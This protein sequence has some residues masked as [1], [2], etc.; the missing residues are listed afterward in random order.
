MTNR[1]L[2][3]AT[4]IASTIGLCS[5]SFTIGGNKAK[6]PP[7]AAQAVPT[8]DAG[9]LSGIE[10]GMKKKQ[11]IDI[12]GIPT[13]RTPLGD[14]LMP[15]QFMPEMWSYRGLGR[16]YFSGSSPQTMESPVVTKVEYDPSEAAAAPPPPEPYGTND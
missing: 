11:V 2:L 12:L 13:L 4:L 5:C 16:I 10:K 15:S 9:P 1:R 6:D 7:A 14:V 8:P 3:I